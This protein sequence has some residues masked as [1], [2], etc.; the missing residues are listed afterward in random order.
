MATGD[1]WVAVTPETQPPLGKPVIA[2]VV[3]GDGWKPA[4]MFGEF[5]GDYEPNRVLFHSDP[6]NVVEDG[7]WALAKVTHWRWPPAWPAE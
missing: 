4:M 1:D 3:P 2:I 6:E 5:D 7:W